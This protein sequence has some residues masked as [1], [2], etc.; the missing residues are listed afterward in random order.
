M[1]NSTRYNAFQAI[2]PFI[3][4]PTGAKNGADVGV[5]M[6]PLTTIQNVTPEHRPKASRM[7]VSLYDLDPRL[8]YSIRVCTIV[9][10]KTIS[11]KTEKLKSKEQK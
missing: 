10:G 3:E 8:E 1:C 2:K 11:R 9:N 5:E 7:K 4:V 6:Q